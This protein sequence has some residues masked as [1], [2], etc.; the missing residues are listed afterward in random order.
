MEWNT[1]A[2]ELLEELL[3]P[4]PIFARPM[5]RKGIEKN[6]IEVAGGETITQNDVVKGYIIASPGKM[7]D[8]A[9]KLLKAKN[10]DLTPYEDLLDAT[11]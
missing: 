5:A 6:I 1:E 8:R 10:I 3:K 11:K 9:V 7:Q 2:K 4:I